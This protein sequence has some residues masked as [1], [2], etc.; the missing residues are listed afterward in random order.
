MDLLK[1]KR[2]LAS[3]LESLGITARFWEIEESRYADLTFKAFKYKDRIQEIAGTLGEH[4]LVSDVKI[5]GPYI[6]L[7]LDRAPFSSAVLTAILDKGREYGK[8]PE[9]GKK[10]ILEHTSVNPTGPIHI[11]R[12]RNPVIGD[13][14]RRILEFLGYDVVV[15]YYVNDVGRQV[16]LITLARRE[17]VKPDPELVKRYGEY[18]DK[19]DF[20]TFFIYVPAYRRSEE[21]R[22]FKA[23]IDELMK[24]AETGDKALLEE[25]RRTAEFCLDGQMETL[26]RCGFH[27]DK[28]VFESEFLADGSVWR[29]VENLKKTGRTKALENG[30]LAIDLRDLGSPREA[31]VLLRPDGTSVYLTR[32]VAYHLRKLEEGD[33]AINVLGEDHKIEFQELKALLGLLGADASKLDVVHFS[34][35]N[36]E[37]GRMSTRRGE[38]V[39]LDAVLDEGVEKALEVIEEKNP[40]L[41]NKKRVAEAVGIG[42]IKYALIKQDPMKQITFRWEDAL[43]FEGDTAPYI[44]YACVRGRSILRKAE[45]KPSPEVEDVGDSEWILVKALAKFPEMVWQA[46]NSR[47]PNLLANYANSLAKQF[48]EFY[49]QERVLGSEKEEFRLALVAGTVTVLENALYLL[50]I[51]VPERM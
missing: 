7:D 44:Q 32:D 5:T 28:M 3:K 15:H 18:S 26:H 19:P 49:H 13:S 36:L 12:F 50:G 24:N 30:A 11:G 47:K 34:F 1:L 38:T 33:L 2:E 21:D 42:A 23:K 51:N 27:Y 22:E 40:E 43:D 29:V 9:N 48:N 17:G 39:P 35:V 31:T 14:L 4:E 37:G 10:L 6:N 20:Q 46:G 45:R 16:A 8:Q 41:K 25:L